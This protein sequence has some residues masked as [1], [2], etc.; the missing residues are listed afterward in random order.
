[1][2]TT[3]VNVLKP[4]YFARPFRNQPHTDRARGISSLP[5]QFTKPSEDLQCSGS[6]TGEFP[7]WLSEKESD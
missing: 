4:F 2:S 1:M 3:L 7:S 6:L 5:A